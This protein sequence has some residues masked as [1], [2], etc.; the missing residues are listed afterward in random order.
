ME[1]SDISYDLVYLTGC[2]LRQQPPDPSYVRTMDL[3]A[4]YAQSRNASLSALVCMALET[5]E[6][7][8]A[9]ELADLWIEDKNKV[10]RKN[11]LMDLDRQALCEDLEE[12]GCWYLPLK[13]SLLKDL[14]PRM[15]MRQ[16]ADN[17][18]LFD[19]SF[20]NAVTQWFLDRDY[21]AV[22]VG[23]SNHD[24]YEKPPFYNFEMH[25]D[26]FS[27]YYNEKWPE[28]FENIAQRLLPLPGTDFGRAMTDEDFYLFFLAHGYKHYAAGGTGLRTLCDERVWLRAKE[29]AMDWDILGSRLKELGLTGFEEDLRL[30]AHRVFDGEFRPEALTDRQQ[31]ILRYLLGSGTYGNWENQVTNAWNAARQEDG[32]RPRYL[33]YLWQ[34]LFPGR[35]F[36]AQLPD[37]EALLKSPWK[38][39]CYN[40]KRLWKALL[41]KKRQ[42]GRELRIIFH[43]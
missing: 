41:S 36:Y 30:L 9:G 37:R 7:G 42:I 32:S 22:S 4:L 20:R 23:E 3:K 18:I 34:R 39:C 26:L 10:I 16:M 1:K 13:G 15:G 38:R 33:R 24:V 14:Y 28:Y 35:D 17:D 6:G 8:F 11:L 2:G 43:K 29:S 19:R 21:E 5:M 12:M 40:T 27:S 25:V 31:E